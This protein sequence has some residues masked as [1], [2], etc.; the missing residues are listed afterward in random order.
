M[1]TSGSRFAAAST[2][3][4]IEP[5]GYGDSGHRRVAPGPPAGQQH[6][7]VEPQDLV[8]RVRPHSGIGRQGLELIGV[9]VQQDDAV[10]QQVHRRLESGG[11]HQTGR[12]L[13]F[14]VVQPDALVAGGD[15]LAEQVLARLCRSQVPRWIV[16]PG[17]EL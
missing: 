3:V 11:E 7:R 10:S 12:R 2:V 6:G 13:Q 17:L 9:L 4:T 1:K 14:T 5:G 15:Q 8:D 16:E